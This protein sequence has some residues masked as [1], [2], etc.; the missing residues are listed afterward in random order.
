MGFLRTLS[1]E[2]HD[3][4]PFLDRGSTAIG[5]LDELQVSPFLTGACPFT[6]V[7]ECQELSRSC[8]VT[9]GC[10][11]DQVGQCDLVRSGR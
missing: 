8:R 1:V 5:D 2:P 6:S 11:E 4:C 3:V 10:N 7:V 9:C